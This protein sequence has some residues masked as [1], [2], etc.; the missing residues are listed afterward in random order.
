MTVPPL[1]FKSPS[2]TLNFS[3]LKVRFQLHSYIHHLACSDSPFLNRRDKSTSVMKSS[4]PTPCHHH[5][6][7]CNIVNVQNQVSDGD[8]Y[9]V[10][11]DQ[12]SGHLHIYMPSVSRKEEE[13][14]KDSTHKNQNSGQENSEA[15]QYQRQLRKVQ[16]EQRATNPS[17]SKLSLLKSKPPLYVDEHMVVLSKPSGLLSVPGLNNNPSVLQHVYDTYGPNN[18]DSAK[19]SE[20]CEYTRN[21]D[22]EQPESAS[23]KGKMSEPLITNIDQMVVHRLDMDTR[24][25]R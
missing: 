10:D 25:V 11:F 24:S 1:I 8:R 13:A 16:A 2:R 6:D 21:G 5:D 23:E 20:A 14:R 7:E 4:R 9:H 18:P 17:P 15:L 3:L 12:Q 19:D 22:N